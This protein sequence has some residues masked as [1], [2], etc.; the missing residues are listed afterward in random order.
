MVPP[1]PYAVGLIALGLLMVFFT[2]SSNITRGCF[3]RKKK[4]LKLLQGKKSWLYKIKRKKC[5]SAQFTLDN[6]KSIL[7]IASSLNKIK[8]RRYPK[9][10]QKKL[11]NR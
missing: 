2:S 6:A 10:N 3:F 5:C 7:I 9:W 8:K 11:Q 4:L 1:T